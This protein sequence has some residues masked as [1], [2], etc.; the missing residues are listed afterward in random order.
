MV[1]L[2]TRTSARQAQER[3]QRPSQPQPRT[4]RISDHTAG[5]VSG[6][7]KSE[8]RKLLEKLVAYL[9]IDPLRDEDVPVLQFLLKI[10]H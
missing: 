10:G 9:Y 7:T 6:G 4:P 5:W 8:E 3:I 1:P 2:A